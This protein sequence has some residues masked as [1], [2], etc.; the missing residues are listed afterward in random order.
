M[1]K[2]QWTI[3]FADI[4]KNGCF[5][6]RKYMKYHKDFKNDLINVTKKLYIL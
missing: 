6:F 1:I 3:I 5:T 2:D 4:E